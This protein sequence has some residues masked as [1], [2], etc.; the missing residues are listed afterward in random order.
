MTENITAETARPPK[1]RRR[2]LRRIGW[3]LLILIAVALVV[4]LVAGLVTEHALNARLDA[5]RAA[6][7]PLR[8]TELA[9][10]EVAPE[11]NAAVLYGQAFV[12]MGLLPDCT[13]NRIAT[14]SDARKPLTP[15]ELDEARALLAQS[16]DALRLIRE[17]TTRPECRFPLKYDTEPLMGM[18]LPHLGR[19]RAAAR[20]L[21]LFAEVNLAEGKP[22]AA[23]EDCAEIFRLARALH[24]E[25]IL[26]SMLVEMANENIG[27]RRL[28]AVLDRSE[29][30]AEALAKLQPLLAVTADRERVRRLMRGERTFGIDAFEL[31]LDHPTQATSWVA[32]LSSYSA[33]PPP[34]KQAWMPEPPLTARI[35][36]GTLVWVFRPVIVNDFS[37]YLDLMG[38][39]IELVGKPWRET[40]DSWRAIEQEMNDMNRCTHPITRTILPALGRV[41]EG[42]ECN[43]AGRECAKTALALRL[44]RLKHGAYPDGLGSLAPE[45]LPSVPKDPFADAQLVYRREG[46]GFVLY[47]VGLNGTDDGGVAPPGGTWANKEGDIVFRSSR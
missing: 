37:A 24:D 25:P 17:G 10:P 18:L 23:V 31:I 22:D 34:P 5:L 6:G 38:R 16:A 39:E 41:S 33:A 9:P 36:S 20:L 29:P 8:M 46:A 32:A 12:F 40:R 28:E 35:F 7:E 14:L 30:S 27:R 47:S 2:W 19:Q 43:F 1:K 45:L 11:R 15:T 13:M 42:F 4:R 44:Y 21:S 3:T 26:I